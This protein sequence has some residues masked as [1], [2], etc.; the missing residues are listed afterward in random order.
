MAEP[1]SHQRFIIIDQARGAM[2]I[3]IFLLHL[4]GIFA[5][6]AYQ[7]LGLVSY[8]EFFLVMAGFV[9]AYLYKPHN[10][11][12]RILRRAAKVYVFHLISFIAVL[13]I[14]W[15]LPAAFTTVWVHIDPSWQ[16]VTDSPLKGLLMAAT[17]LF[18]PKYLEI[19]PLYVW[20]TLI[21][22]PVLTYMN[23]RPKQAFIVVPLISMVIWLAGQYVGDIF[24]ALESNILPEGANLGVFMPH[25][26][27]VY[28][29]AG[30]WLSFY[31]FKQKKLTITPP[32]GMHLYALM[33]FIGMFLFLGKAEHIMPFSRFDTP[34]MWLEHYANKRSVGWLRLVNVGLLLYLA[35]WFSKVRPRWVKL[36]FLTWLS[37]HALHVFTLQAPLVYGGIMLREYYLAPYNS[38]LMYYAT[39]AALTSVLVLILIA[40]AYH[41]EQRRMATKKRQV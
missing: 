39:D 15:R 3:G 41:H 28:Y 9:A 17:L 6:L 31:T 4:E 32:Q 8:V 37:R 25:L 26:W 21:S 33:I 10:F 11:G 29:V 7:P 22:Y 30:L 2:L 40:V 16:L 24:I 12:T 23:S 20:M 34:L 14:F 18:Q 38:V 19:L 5:P 13:F 35:Y 1:S 36:S 27:Q